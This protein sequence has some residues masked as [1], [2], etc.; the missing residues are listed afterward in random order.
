MCDIRVVGLV[1][2]LSLCLFACDS[3]QNEANTV[4]KLTPVETV[5]YFTDTGLSNPIANIQHPLVNTPMV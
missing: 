3:T 2:V 5:D 1:I 4:L